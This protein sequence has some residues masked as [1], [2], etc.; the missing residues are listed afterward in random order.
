M[1]DGR[2]YTLE[3]EIDVLHEDLGAARRRVHDLEAAP[4]DSRVADPIEWEDT[5]ANA[6]QRVKFLEHELSRFQNDEGPLS[7][8]PSAR[9]ATAVNHD[10]AQRM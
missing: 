2:V 3:D 8:A 7:R 10:D 5:L 4:R 9:F 6:R 1:T